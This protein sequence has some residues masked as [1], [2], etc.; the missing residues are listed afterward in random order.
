MKTD[1]QKA[2]VNLHNIKHDDTL[3][4]ETFP[5][6]KVWIEISGIGWL[7]YHTKNAAQY[8]RKEQK[9]KFYRNRWY[10]DSILA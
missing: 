6:H 1:E 5:E 7:L 9:S 2:N 3:L 10:A 4:R 8:L